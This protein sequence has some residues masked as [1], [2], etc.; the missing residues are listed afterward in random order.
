MAGERINRISGKLAIILSALA[1]LT[2]VSG[3]FQPPQQDESTAAHLFQ[4]SVVALVPTVLLF[5][6]TADWSHPLRSVRPLAVSVATL[7]LAFG[8]LY[9]LEHYG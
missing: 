1:L 7:V 2:V 5:L 8:A 4:F 6:A 3:Y 9:F